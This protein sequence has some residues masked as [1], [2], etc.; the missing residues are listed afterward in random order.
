MEKI[1]KTVNR[2]EAEKSRLYLESLIQKG[3]TCVIGT[4]GKIRTL[5]QN[6]LFHVW[7]KVIAD[8]IGELSYERCKRDVKRT[9]LGTK[10]EVNRFTGEILQV[11]YETSAMTVKELASFM[12]KIKIWAQTDLGCYLP[13]W[14]DPGYEEMINEYKYKK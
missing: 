8:E 12:D 4:K 14:K 3:E 7:I 1:F 2:F 13:Y 5:D 6:A 9:L 10:E 11:D